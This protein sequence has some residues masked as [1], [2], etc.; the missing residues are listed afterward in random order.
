M[1]AIGRF[2]QLLEA[3]DRCLL[4]KR[5]R[6]PFELIDR[7][8]G[9]TVRILEGTEPSTYVASSSEL[10]ILALRNGDELVTWDTTANKVLRRR[11]NVP[12]YSA[13]AF[14]RDGAVIAVGDGHGVIQLWDAGTLEPRGA[15][16]LGHSETILD[17]A[18]SPDR[19]TLASG[20]VDGTVKLWDVTTNEEFLTLQG[21]NGTVIGRPC[22]APDGRTLGLYAQSGD[23]NRVYLLATA[24]PAGVDAKEGR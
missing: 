14:S 22:F 5:S 11:L 1:P 2:D 19:R 17:L 6:G 3:N 16:L 8:T 10:D 4:V 24:L 18:F 7:A 13:G 20:S 9:A 21:P 15:P 12:G 23:G